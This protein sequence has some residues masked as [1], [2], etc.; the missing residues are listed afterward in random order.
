M[1]DSD[2]HF[3]YKLISNFIRIPVS[4]AL[5]AIFPR[6]LGPVNYGNFDFLT[7][8]ATK[9]IG[10]F[11]TGT[12]IAFYTNLSINNKDIKLI[13]FYW[14]LVFFISL[15]YLFFILITGFLNL[16]HLFWPEQAFYFIILSAIWGIVT[17]SSNTIYKMLD[18]CHVTIASEKFRT[19]QLLF[20]V[21]VFGIIYFLSFNVNLSVFF[22]IQIL[23]I[24]ILF[25]GSWYILKNNGF[26]VF[27]TIKL[28][29][30][31][32]SK[33]KK[34]F[35]TFSSPLLL[36]AL[37]SLI[38]G[39]GERWILQKFGGPVQQAHFGISYKI[40]S[41]V[42]L[43]TSAMIPIMLREFSKL[44]GTNDLEEIKKY[45]NKTIKTFL[46]LATTLAVLVA[47]NAEFITFI[48][49][50]S[51]FKGATLV[52]ALMA[53]YPIHQT[54][55]QINATLFYSTNRTKNY[56]NIGLFIIPIGLIISF[57]L[58]APKSY[59]GFNL[60]AYGLVCQMLIVQLL[61]TNV[62]LYSNS[63]YLK[64][65]YSNFLLIQILTIGSLVFLSYG[66]QLF[67]DIFNLGLLLRAILFTI[68]LFSILLLVFTIFPKIIGFNI[69]EHFEKSNINKKEKRVT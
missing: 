22:I 6:I 10:F 15:A 56:R 40:G 18:A 37:F 47:F 51:E 54:I 64:T 33:F 11:E 8:S 41:F 58:I 24:L 1:R 16:S 4:F 50:G 7:D 3:I 38:G 59:G 13:K 21:L 26:E 53:F 14:R 20:S 17:F 29:F 45:F 67:V 60:G 48:L 5:Q 35:W 30:N 61:S 9:F 28:T 63:K 52:V 55:G 66:L 69:L 2:K 44:F 49:G 27:P 36:Y 34:L 42:F 68:L 65:K 32:L 46:I 43:F 12:S 39:V 57:L 31:D 19:F 62:M 25:G 23:L